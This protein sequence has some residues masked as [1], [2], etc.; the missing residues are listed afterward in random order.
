M[1][2]FNIISSSWSDNTATVKGR[3]SY[4]ATLLPSGVI[5]YIGG[6]EPINDGN[7]TFTVTSDISQIYL[8]DTNSL[9]WSNMVCTMNY[10]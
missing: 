6:Y 4:T 8:Y 7:S 10:N 1:V 5:V 3:S 2:D 9:T